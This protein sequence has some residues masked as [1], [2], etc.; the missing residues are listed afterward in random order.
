MSRRPTAASPFAGAAKRLRVLG[1]LLSSA[2]LMTCGGDSGGPTNPPAPVAT[3]VSVTPAINT[4]GP[5]QSV[6][7]AAVVRDATGATM[8]GAAVT[9]RTSDAAVATVTSGG[10]ATGI[11][12]GAAT[13]TATSGSAAGT[14]QITVQLANLTVARDTTLSGTLV[15]DDFILAA[16]ATVTATGDLTVDAAGDV[17]IDGSLEGDCVAVTLM[18]GGDQLR[19]TGKI[20]NPC[21]AGGGEDAPGLTILA[22]GDLFF[23]GA[24]ILS[25]GDLLISNDTGVPAAAVGLPL[26]VHAFVARVLAHTDRMAQSA[27]DKECIYNGGTFETQDGKNG[28]S[29]T[30]K[31]AD[32]TNAGSLILDCR[33]TLRS[34]GHTY[35]TGDGGGGGTGQSTGTDGPAVGGTGGASGAIF[36]LADAMEFDAG[37]STLR[38]GD[39]GTGGDAEAQGT[40]DSPDAAATGG[41][42]GGAGLPQIG[43]RNFGSETITVSPGSLVFE[44]GKS[45]S[46]GAA[47]AFAED[48]KDATSSEEAKPGGNA[49]ATGGAGADDA[50]GV[51]TATELMRGAVGGDMQNIAY[52]IPPVGD[53]G[54]ASGSAGTGGT[55]SK[56]FKAGAVG[57]DLT[58]R[59]GAGGK[60]VVTDD[61]FFVPTYPSDP[62][63]GGDA[64]FR[65]AHGGFG[66]ADCRVD[67]G[68]GIQAGGAGAKGGTVQGEAG[69]GGVSPGG[70]SGA[71]G[72]GELSTVGNGGD[73]GAGD[74]PGGRGA[75]G[76]DLI[77]GPRTDAGENFEA[78]SDGGTCSRSFDSN[79]QLR[80]DPTDIESSLG[81]VGPMD[82]F[83]P[84]GPG[85]AIGFAGELPLPT[86]TG[87]F[88]PATGGFTANGSRDVPVLGGN[89]NFPLTGTLMVD[90]EGRL[91]GFTGVLSVDS[92]SGSAVYDVNGDIAG[93]SVIIDSP[94]NGSVHSTNQPIS[95]SSTVTGGVGPFQYSWSFGAGSGIPDSN[96]SFPSVQYAME[97]NFTVTVTVTD[98]NGAMV[99]ASVL[100]Q[101]V[102]A[103]GVDAPV[104]GTEE[105]VPVPTGFGAA[106]AGAVASAASLDGA[107]LM[108]EDGVALFN[109]TTGTF[110]NVLFAGTMFRGGLVATPAG[111]PRTIVGFNLNETLVSYFDAGTS[112]FS[113]PVQ[114]IARSANA[115]TMYGDD[116]TASGF[117]LTDPAA[118][119][120]YD[121]NPAT[122]RFEAV[123]DFPTSL[124]PGETEALASAFG[125]VAGGSMLVAFRGSPGKLWFHDGVAGN[126][127]TLIGDLGSRPQKLHCI[128][129]VCIV[130]NR[131]DDNVSIITWDA[132]DNVSIT[133]SFPT[134]RSP[135]GS[136]MI[137]LGNGNLAVVT[138]DRNDSGFT[139]AEIAP[140][141]GLVSASSLIAPERC[142]SPNDVMWLRDGTTDFVI[143]CVSG[144]NVFVLTAELGG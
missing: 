86:L 10:L 57:G 47:S 34:F 78:G 28:S 63:S 100:V 39:G 88:A 127:A 26:E 38:T 143:T 59:G 109:T 91:L 133:G 84:L 95:F 137:R 129:D 112:Q 42:G 85:T 83:V 44:Q 29:G 110:G 70:E 90:S 52:T 13:I 144:D 121:L 2:S 55:G 23:D 15:V 119:K 11:G 140:S 53:G 17:V 31:G 102:D 4:V 79:F 81:L 123:G 51:T 126:D 116:P 80:T 131:N 60:V 22:E 19:A 65:G 9:W 77:T 27:A 120:T 69:S 128:D 114:L 89:T 37:T 141:G 24:E 64:V 7:F 139:V 36:L 76:D 138:A 96:G 99:T 75:Q 1:A 103:V 125:H 92:P 54:R 16:G 101:L 68:G 49:E 107:L 87:D 48:G 14:A 61:R 98:A 94:Q 106:G 136:D 72:D 104:S 93:L 33:G 25:G 111:G 108:A 132:G 40:D 130:T 30:P 74:P 18:S 8:A 71:A 97:G 142:G 21:A 122:Q 6:Q 20:A 67:E 46:G 124:F 43:S 105:L 32:G 66:W 5:G 115:A 113:T 45:G 50:G 62:G 35:V 56:E 12:T 3:T 135:R 117:V 41:D 73:G 58:V 82:I 118:V 134:G